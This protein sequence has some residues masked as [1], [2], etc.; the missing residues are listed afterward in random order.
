MLLV[1]SRPTNK[2]VCTVALALLYVSSI[3]FFLVNL[4][5]SKVKLDYHAVLNK[6]PMSETPIQAP[7]ST[8]P[9]TVSK[10]HYLQPIYTETPR[11]IWYKLGPAGL[12]D[13]TLA[14]TETCTSQ[15]PGYRVE[16]LTDDSADTFVAETFFSRPDLVATYLALTIPILKADLLR[17]LLLY[18]E[19]GVWFDLDVSCSEIPID[20]WIPDRYE[21]LTDLV[22]GWEFDAGFPHP[23]QRQFTI[24]TIMAKAGTS[25]LMAVV[26]DILHDIWEAAA[27][28]NVTVD[29]LKMEMVGDVVDM[30]G[31][32][33]FTRSVL[34]S[35]EREMGRRVEERSISELVRP[36]L[37]GDVL[38]MPGFS[39]ARGMNRYDKEKLGPVLVTHHYAG[40]WK[41]EFGGELV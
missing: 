40:S 20:N 14:W 6:Q 1:P 23:I 17:Y 39:F 30:T 33:R 7:T 11:K 28:H 25:H 4:H 8:A 41:N 12:N 36:K 31:P 24:W 35:V 32:R 5:F 21:A 13:E 27:R 26:E 19:G 3:L 29:G 9:T 37:V 10:A 38:I 2:F 22:V 34:S 18:A 15:N 16:F